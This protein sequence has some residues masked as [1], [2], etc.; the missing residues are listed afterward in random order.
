MMFCSLLPHRVEIVGKAKWEETV[1]IQK[2][3]L[4]GELILSLHTGGGPQP[5]AENFISARVEQLSFTSCVVL[6]A[7]RSCMAGGRPT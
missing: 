1:R 6:F 3:V 5:Y 7:S 4:V 2:Y